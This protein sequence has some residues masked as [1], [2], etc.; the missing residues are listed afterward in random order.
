MHQLNCSH[1]GSVASRMPL[2]VALLLVFIVSACSKSSSVA[3]LQ[4]DVDWSAIGGAA[5]A[6]ISWR[7]DVQPV[8]EKRC[9]VCHG[10]YDAPCQLKLTS[11]EGIMR[12]PNPR[13]V[14]DGR[15]RWISMEESSVRART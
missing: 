5:E 6:Q 3:D 8:L 1:R 11:Y 14:Y 15:M 13:K 12:G 4:P 2:A 10:C 7:E 9:V